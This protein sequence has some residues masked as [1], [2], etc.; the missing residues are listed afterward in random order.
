MQYCSEKSRDIF[1]KHPARPLSAA[2]SRHFQD[3]TND[4]EERKEETRQKEQVKINKTEA[5]KG[6]KKAQSKR[7]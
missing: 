1:L 4:N 6:G 5:E 2:D 7:S 3:L